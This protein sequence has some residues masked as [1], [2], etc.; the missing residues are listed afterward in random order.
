MLWK[1]GTINK[2]SKMVEREG[3][4]RERAVGEDQ[5]LVPPR[6]HTTYARLAA[7][8][9]QQQKIRNADAL[10]RARSVAKQTE[11]RDGGERVFCEQTVQSQLDS[12]RIR[13]SD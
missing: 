5:L 13:A 2:V 8:Q 10:A 3:D 9:S 4:Y 1:V 11:R 6:E 7:Q 12:D